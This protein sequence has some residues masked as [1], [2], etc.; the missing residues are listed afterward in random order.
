MPQIPSYPWYTYLA[1]TLCW[2]LALGTLWGLLRLWCRLLARVMGTVPRLLDLGW[3]WCFGAPLSSAG[4]SHWALAKEVKAAGLLQPEGLPLAAWQHTVLHEPSGSHVLVMGPPRSGKSWGLAMPV[5]RAWPGAVVVSDLRHELFDQTGE[6]R[7]AYGPVYCYDPA[8]ATNSCNL[9]ILDSVR[10]GTPQAYGDVARIVH[11]LV[12]P[13]RDREP[14]PFDRPAM[15]L[16]TGVILHLRDLSDASFPAVVDWMQ[17]PS[18]SQRDKLEEMLHSANPHVASAARRVLDESERFRAT[19]WDTAL[20][21]LE[22]FRDPT[23][24]DHSRRS[25]LDWQDFLSGRHPTSL[26]LCMNFRD[27]DRLGVILGALVEALIAL[28]GSPARTP[29]HRT[30][31]LLDELANLGTLTELERGVSY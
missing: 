25:D 23:I 11:H 31:L 14:G 26:F 12:L 1:L 7:A 13:Q 6:A 10:W 20:A 22:V 27:I 28:L 19:V 15:A 17:A 29:R 4:T 21:P 9:N 24:A 18:R 16:L 8:N 2:L 30:L 3:L 5:L